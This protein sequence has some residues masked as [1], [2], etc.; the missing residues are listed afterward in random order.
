MSDRELVVCSGV[1][2]AP[3]VFYKN[4][5]LSYGLHLRRGITDE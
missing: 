4:L 2:G 5:K 3:D 1:F